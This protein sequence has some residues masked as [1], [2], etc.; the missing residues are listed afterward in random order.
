MN[1]AHKVIPTFVALLLSGSAISHAQDAARLT[2]YK[3]VLPIFQENCQACH[4]PGGDN[5]AGMVAPFSLMTYKESRPW[6][7]AIAKNVKAKTMP[8]WFATEEFHGQFQNERTLTD[9]EINTIVRWAATG[10]AR[11]RAEDAPSEMVFEGSDGWMTGKPDLILTMPEPYFVDE[12][13]DDEYVNFVTEPLTEEQLPE[14]RWLRA[15]EWRGDSEVVHHIVGAASIEG[16]D[17]EVQRFELGSIAPGEEGTKYPE[18]YGKLLRKG[19]RIHFN[20]HYHKEAGKGTGVWDQSL[21]GFRFW[22]EGKDPEIQHY[23][24]RN[25]IRNRDFEIPPG[26]PNWEVSAAQT[27]EHDTTLLSLHPHMHL[28]GKDARYEIVYPDGRREALL[29]VP[30]FDFNWQLDYTFATPKRVPAGSRVEFTVHYDNSPDNIYNPDPTIPM[31]WG[32]PTTSEMMIGYVSWSNTKPM[33]F[34]DKA[35]VVEE[36]SIDEEGEAPDAT[37]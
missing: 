36:P 3:D 27:F 37:D 22:D 12:D 24:H 34:S 33:D 16:P 14:D 20:M 5:I 15:I 23:V 17:G 18:G 26:H 25:G 19:S 32:G 2:F 7:K 29:D 10:A 11:G 30:A 1:H 21:V 8:P 13:V 4:R 9:A 31:V 6:A 35:S 28:R